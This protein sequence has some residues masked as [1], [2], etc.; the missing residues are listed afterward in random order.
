MK[1]NEI[2]HLTKPFVFF[3]PFHP[4]RGMVQVAS[5]VDFGKKL[6]CLFEKKLIRVLSILFSFTSG[7]ITFE[8]WHTCYLHPVYH[9]NES[10]FVGCFP[11]KNFHFASVI[12]SFTGSTVL[13]SIFC[14]SASFSYLLSRLLYLLF[15]LLSSLFYVLFFVYDRLLIEEEWKWE[16]TARLLPSGGEKKRDDKEG[17]TKKL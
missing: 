6:F 15:C 16:S 2:C 13:P 17:K 1:N 4:G 12:L 11:Q 3:I 14:L 8:E 9:A 5:V 10:L 7:S